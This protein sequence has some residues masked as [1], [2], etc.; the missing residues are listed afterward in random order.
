[1]ITNSG[2]REGAEVVQLYIMDMESSLPRP[3]KELKG[4]KKVNLAPGET[5]K[6]NFTIGK[7]ALSFYT[8]E[9]HEWVVEP[10]K[11]Q[12]LVGTASDDIR[13]SATFSVER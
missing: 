12:I 7:E 9:R 13:S 5:V 10:C 1:P 4:F 2:N 3:L 6:V 11:F 8:P